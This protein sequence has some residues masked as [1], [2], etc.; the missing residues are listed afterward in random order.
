M[1]KKHLI[2]LYSISFIF[3]V[4]VPVFFFY[5]MTQMQFSYLGYSTS[6]YSVYKLSR[7]SW[8]IVDIG[9]M[10]IMV[11]V[12]ASNLIFKIKKNVLWPLRY[13]FLLLTWIARSMFVMPFLFIYYQI[14]DSYYYYWSIGFE[15]YVI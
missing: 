14:K 11:V 6:F 4:F 15:R 8:D 1:K 2:L 5:E 7:S 9:L 3:F 10:I 13:S 12:L